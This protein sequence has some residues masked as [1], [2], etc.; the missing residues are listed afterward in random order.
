MKSLFIKLK[1]I[2]PYI[3]L[4]IIYF[5]FINLEARKQ[6]IINMDDKENQIEEIQ[7]KTT[8]GK[9]DLSYENKNNSK[10]TIPVIPYTNKE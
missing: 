3:L 8:Q 7:I 6:R 1:N 5:F 2:Y 9:K 10:L 4:V